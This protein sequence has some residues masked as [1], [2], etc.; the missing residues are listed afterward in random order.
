MTRRSS[1]LRCQFDCRRSA[2]RQYF[3][4]GRESIIAISNVLH[5]GSNFQELTCTTMRA[6]G[7]RA[8]NA[9]SF[10]RAPRRVSFQFDSNVQNTASRRS[11][12]F[13]RGQKKQLNDDL[14]SDSIVRIAKMIP[15][16]PGDKLTA[17]GKK[18]TATAFVST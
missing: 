14:N 18:F 10:F 5:G 6:N 2:G 1:Y 13:I 17:A 4:I 11:V 16:P 9:K 3:D 7:E 12:I 8:A 15:V